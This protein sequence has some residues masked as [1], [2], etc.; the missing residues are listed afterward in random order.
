MHTTSWDEKYTYNSIYKFT[1]VDFNSDRLV[2]SDGELTT[3]IP[4]GTVPYNINSV[5]FLSKLYYIGSEVIFKYLG[6][7]GLQLKPSFQH[8]FQDSV[9]EGETILANIFLFEI[10]V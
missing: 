1:V 8:A 4:I 10:Q 9:C 2:I 7:T 3:D 6:Q 5:L